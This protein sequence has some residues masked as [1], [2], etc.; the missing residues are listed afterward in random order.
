MRPRTQFLL[1][2]SVKLIVELQNLSVALAIAKLPA[3]AKEFGFFIVLSAGKRVISG[4][5]RQ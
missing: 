5:V 1:T 2:I 4:R 3:K